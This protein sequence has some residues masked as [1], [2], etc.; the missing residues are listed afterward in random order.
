MM[1]GARLWGNR[2]NGKNSLLCHENTISR[3]KWVKISSYVSN[4]HPTKD[5]KPSIFWF[6]QHTGTAITYRVPHNKEHHEI[7][8][9]TA[10]TPKVHS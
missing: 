1:P 10:D 3:Q 2:Q 8:Y 9:E 7:D 4:L 6:R 5:K